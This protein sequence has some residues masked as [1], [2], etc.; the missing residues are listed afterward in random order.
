MTPRNKLNVSVLLQV[1]RPSFSI[2][3][4]RRHA[5]DSKMDDLITK[6]NI[7][8]KFHGWRC[9]GGAQQQEE[10]TG[11][12]LLTVRQ[13]RW[14]PLLSPFSFFADTISPQTERGAHVA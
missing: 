3:S 14:M 13:A 1:E 6:G 11:S 7:R 9:Y 2:E 5:A 10:P 8:Q 4:L 12:A